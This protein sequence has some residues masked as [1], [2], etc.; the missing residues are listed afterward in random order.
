MTGENLYRIRVGDYR[1]I[2][3]ISDKTVTVTVAKAAHRREAYR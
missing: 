2:Y 1:A 3:A